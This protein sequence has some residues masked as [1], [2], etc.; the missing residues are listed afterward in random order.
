MVII[1]GRSFEMAKRDH[2]LTKEWG[3]EG[4]DAAPD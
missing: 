4:A 1:M 2:F 3:F